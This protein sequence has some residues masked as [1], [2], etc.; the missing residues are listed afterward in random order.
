MARL[1][2]QRVVRK[3]NI[4]IH[5]GAT[6]G[7]RFFIDH[8]T[9]VVIGETAIIGDDVTIYQGVTLGALSFPKDACGMLI[10]GQKRHP[11]IENDVIIYAGATVLGDIV[12]GSHSIIGGNVWV[13]ESLEPNTKITA[14]LPEHFVKVGKKDGTK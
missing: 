14:K 3:T 6:I 11:T 7:R 13:T 1:I 4:E 2:S 5:P 10:K 8:G 9:G 12:I